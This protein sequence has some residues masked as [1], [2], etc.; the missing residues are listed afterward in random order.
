MAAGV[1]R[2]GARGRRAPGRSARAHGAAPVG[3]LRRRRAV[4][5]PRSRRASRVRS[6]ATACGTSR[7]RRTASSRSAST[8]S[9]SEVLAREPRPPPLGLGLLRRAAG[10]PRLDPPGPGR[11]RARDG[12]PCAR[13]ARAGA[14]AASRA[15]ASGS[16]CASPREN[17]HVLADA[18]RG[19]RARARARQ[20]DDQPRARDR[21]RASLLEVDIA[22]YEEVVASQAAARRLAARCPTSTSRSRAL[23]VARDR[24]D[25]RA[26]RARRARRRARGTCPARR[27]RSPP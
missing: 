23:A 22:R 9:S 10:D 2:A 15:R 16:S 13:S 26:R 4:P 3:Q 6:A 1:A 17:Q 7:S 14:S 21:A 8:R 27:A 25:V 18:R 12:E 24:P 19:A 5:A 11:A 20:R